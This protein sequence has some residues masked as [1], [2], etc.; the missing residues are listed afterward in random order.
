MI[1]FVS[2]SASIRA[3]AIMIFAFYD[4]SL[5]GDDPEGDCGREDL[6]NE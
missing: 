6:W 2:T 1:S 4:E 5:T 3:I